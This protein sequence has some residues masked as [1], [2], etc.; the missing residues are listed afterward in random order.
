MKAPT[1]DI[2]TQDGRDAL[3]K[4]TKKLLGKRGKRRGEIADALG[5]E[6]LHASA[7]LRRLGAAGFARSEGHNNGCVW[8][9]A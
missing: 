9:K 3:D 8:F 6:P 1:Y 5:V 2:H 7:S 4:A